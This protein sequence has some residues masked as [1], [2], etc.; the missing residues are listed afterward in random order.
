MQNNIDIV[1]GIYEAMERGDLSAVV[2]SFGEDC[3]IELMGPATIP[4]AGTYHGPDAMQRFIEAFTSS[5]DILDF[6]PDELHADGNF[7]VALGHERARAKATGREW[8]TRLID[9]YEVRDG[10]VHTFLCAYDT[11]VVADAF[12]GLPQQVGESKTEAP[13]P[14][15]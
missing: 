7:V 11:A 9:M 13:R 3:T 4:F 12:E 14:R 6:G 8:K 15:A 2:E 1:R 10:K 5:A